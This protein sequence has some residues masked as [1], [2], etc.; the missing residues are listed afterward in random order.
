VLPDAIKGAAPLDSLYDRSAQRALFNLA[1]KI[2]CE[3]EQAE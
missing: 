2:F 3:V 1:F